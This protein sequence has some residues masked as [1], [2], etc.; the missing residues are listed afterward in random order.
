MKIVLNKCYGG[1]GVSHEAIM[2]YGE[3]KGVEVVLYTNDEPHTGDSTIF[4]RITVEE[5]EELSDWA[6]SYVVN[7]P[8]GD[9]FEVDY[10][11]EDNEIPEFLS[12]YDFEKYRAD[13]EFIQT[14]EELG[15][16]ASGR[17]ANLVVVEIPDGAEYD[18]SDYDGVE[19]A[20]Y[21]FQMGSV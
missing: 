8:E 20:H 1:F 19:T 13:P 17:F 5:M 7:P 10:D 21:G 15:K 12:T 2:R 14:V 18:I 16:L 11:R 4:K 6:I 3:L 9:T